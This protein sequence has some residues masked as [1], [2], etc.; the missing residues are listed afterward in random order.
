VIRS[1]SAE[2]S[3]AWGSVLFSAMPGG[4]PLG[5]E[6]RTDRH[7]LPQRPQLFPYRRR[8]RSGAGTTSTNQPGER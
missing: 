5:A 1:S 6:A 3:R 8:V 4:Y 2:D 7:K